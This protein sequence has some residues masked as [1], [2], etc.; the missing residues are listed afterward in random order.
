MDMAPPYHLLYVGTAFGDAESPT[1]AILRIALSSEDGALSIAAEPVPTA[2]V[3]PGWMSR[4][5]GGKFVYVA[6]EDDPGSLQAFAIGAGGGLTP[7]GEPVSS[8]GRHPC[9]CTLD[10]TGKWLLA[11]NYS[12]GSVSVVPVLPDGSLGR[13]TDSKHHGGATPPPL[14]DRQEAAHAHSVLLHPS[15]KWAVACDLGLSTVFVYGFDA[16]YGALRGS[17]DDPRHLRAAPDDGCRHAC[18][19]ESGKILFVLNEFRLILE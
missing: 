9:Y 5:E 12:S 3:N 15:N 1:H 17:A 8:A 6:M 16:E 7:I 14:H 2:G 13:P 18:W 4:C 11:A 10:R 19:D